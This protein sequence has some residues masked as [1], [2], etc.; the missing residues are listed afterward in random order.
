MCPNFWTVKKGECY[1]PK[2]MRL[3]NGFGNINKLSGNRRKPYRAR[4]FDGY[5]DDGKRKYKNIGYYEKYNEALTALV[6]YHRN[7]YEFQSDITFA[8]LFDKWSQVK[9]EKISQSNIN[10]YKASYSH[11]KTIHNKPL[12]D[13]TLAQLQAIIDNSGKNYP[14][15]KKI[16][17]FL[18]QMYDYAVMQDI[19]GKDKDKTEYID[20]GE[21]T[22][23][24]LHYKFTNKEIDALWKWSPNNDY[25]QVI[26]ML[27]YCGARAGEFFNIKKADVNM[28]EEYFNII[29]G[30]NANAKRRVPIHHKVMPFYENWMSKDGEYLITKL[31]G[32]RF[33]FKTDHRQY[34]DSYWKP[35]L[36]DIGI[37]EYKNEDGEMKEHLPHDAR[38]TFTSMWKEKK[39]D[40]TFRRK[41]QGHSGKGI[42]EQVYTHIDMENLKAEINQL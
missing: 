26:L 19:I 40:E 12:K 7:P 14:T 3:P 20:I 22:E 29:E 42:G 9:F 38:H 25:V 36:K 2:P 37:L 23:S 27:I 33:D 15:L 31:N 39:L 8:E 41:I 18:S 5:T 11:C 28:E 6:D 16:K 10:G 32:K 13:I 34:T 24:N 30:K 17:T 35:L 1:M 4:V 21:K